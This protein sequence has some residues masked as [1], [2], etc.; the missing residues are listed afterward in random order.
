MEIL[1]PCL[2]HC[3]RICNNNSQ[4]GNKEYEV[5]WFV[6]VEELEAV[7]AHRRNYFLQIRALVNNRL[8]PQLFQQIIRNVQLENIIEYLEKDKLET[9]TV[10]DSFILMF[11]AYLY[12][13]QTMNRCREM[14]L[15]SVD[16]TRDDILLAYRRGM[17]IVGVCSVCH[18]DED[19]LIRYPCGHKIHP[20]CTKEIKICRICML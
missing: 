1:Q 9:S 2:N 16:S 10:R 12:E 4:K 8:Y 13:L 17:V 6:V 14:M 11:K 5:H 18:G 15:L 19:L 20:Y 3:I 7:K